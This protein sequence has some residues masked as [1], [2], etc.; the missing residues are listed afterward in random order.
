MTKRPG[1]DQGMRLFR[2][3][4][5]VG[6]PMSELVGV[7]FSAEDRLAETPDDPIGA[8]PVTP[9][10]SAAPVTVPNKQAELVPQFLGKRDVL[11]ENFS[12]F[13]PGDLQDASLAVQVLDTEPHDFGNARPRVPKEFHLQPGL[14]GF[15]RGDEF[16]GF[17]FCDVGVF[18]GALSVEVGG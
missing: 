18:A 5:I 2:D 13:E 4:Q 14:F 6:P 3:D 10:K 9:E 1:R 12:A 8:V 15:G 11:N 17:R 16:V 7:D